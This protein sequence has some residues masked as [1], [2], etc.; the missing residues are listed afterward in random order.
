MLIDIYAMSIDIQYVNPHTVRISTDISIDIHGMSYYTCMSIEVL[1]VDRLLCPAD[2]FY[3]IWCLWPGF[4]DANF[5]TY[6]VP[7]SIFISR[8]GN[9]TPFVLLFYISLQCSRL[10]AMGKVRL[11][12]YF[13]GLENM[14]FHVIFKNHFR[15]SLQRVL[16]TQSVPPRNV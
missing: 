13:N 8:L 9:A 11:L 15:Q 6:A 5:F 1:Y 4:K 10:A 2:K 12:G 16:C 7:S 3:R 14:N